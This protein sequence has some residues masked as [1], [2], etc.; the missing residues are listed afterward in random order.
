M[1][2]HIIE[3]VIYVKDELNLEYPVCYIKQ[4]TYENESFKYIF[5]P[6]YTVIDLLSP[7][8]FQGIPGLNLELKKEEYVRENKTPTFIYERTPQENREDLWD[9]LDEVGLEYLDK[10]KWLI[11]T[12]KKYTGDNL[13]VKLYEKPCY[14]NQIKNPVYKDIF[15]TGSI[16]ELYSE[17]Y[18]RIKTILSVVIS[19]A[20]LQAGKFEVNNEQRSNLYELLY[21]MYKYEYKKRRDAHKKALNNKGNESTSK[22]RNRIYVSL[23]K[24][25]EMNELFTNNKIS[26]IQ[27]MKELGISSR[28]TFY[29]RLK[30]FREQ[31]IP[32]DK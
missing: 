25:A 10:L 19:G 8:F 22:G 31:Y 9:L 17:T 24:L 30:E 7:S 23:P 14:K 3:G 1:K 27:A 21:P 5:K 16:D 15:K 11:K 6:Y 4:I 29:R 26:E 12:D 18:H 32:N 20:T 28:S 13:F 2:E